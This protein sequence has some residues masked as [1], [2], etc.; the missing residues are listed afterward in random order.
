L[1]FPVIDSYRLAPLLLLKF[2]MLFD[3]ISDNPSNN[4][5]PE[6]KN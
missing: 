2:E 4:L 6:K 1:H 5:V 3:A